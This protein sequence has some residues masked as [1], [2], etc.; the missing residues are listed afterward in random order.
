MT[1]LADDLRRLDEALG[2]FTDGAPDLPG[3]QLMRESL[4]HRREQ[5]LEAM[6]DQALD[7]ALERSARRGTGA[8]LK[9]VSSVLAS[10]QDSLSSIAQTFAGRPTTRGLI[11]SAIVESVELRVSAAAPG[12]LKLSLAPAF[13]ETQVP[14]FEDGEESA[15]ELSVRRLVEVL[16]CADDPAI[17]I[18]S[19]IADLGPRAATHIQ[20]LTKALADG[21]AD[22]TLAWRS[23]RGSATV[24]VRS[25]AA[26]RLREVMSSV[27]E[28]E[29]T[30]VFT[31]RLV[32]GSLI[33]ATFELELDDGSVLRGA[34]D[35]DVLPGLEELFGKP[36]TAQIVVRQLR[37]HTGE[38]KEDH[39]LTALAP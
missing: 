36:C 24:A 2:A 8:E 22:L 34:V 9:L 25:G 26:A 39:R 10:L 16:Q 18:L 11:P 32:G 15:L 20:T 14:L 6:I 27:E 31:G 3:V 23:P 1:G 13:P 19:S 5:I 4:E 17:E 7:V 35:T 38:T 29:R 12:S 28:D 37:L 33:R 30:V 21:A